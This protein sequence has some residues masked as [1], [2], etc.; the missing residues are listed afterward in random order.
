VLPVLTADDDTWHDHSAHWWETETNWWSFNVPERKLGGWLYTQALGVQQVVNGGAWVWDDS[1]AGAIYERNQKGL[2][3]PERGDLRDITFPNGV[4]VQA[5]EPLMKYRTTYSDPGGFQ[6]DLLHEGIMPPHSHAIGAWPFWATRHFD[7]PM[8]VTGT[9]VLLGEELPIDCYSVRDRSW[10][11]RPM[12]PTPPDKRL[13]PGTLKRD[14][15]PARA[16]RPH[17]VGYAFATQDARD[18]FMAFTDPWIDEEGVAS[19]AV[20][21]GYLLRDGEYAPLVEGSRWTTLAEGTRFIQTI[22]LEARDTLGRELKADGRLVSRHG[23]TGPGGTGLF[24]WT[25]S[26]GREGWGEDQS[27]GPAEW[28]EALDGA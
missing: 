27:Y 2:P 3:F 19:D 1:D 20:D 8:H 23:T 25:W 15:P 17:S 7:Q 18:A 9:I 28:F 16:R 22:H 26:G 12:G 10:G 5:L 24:H 6:C 13:P 14:N 4:S 11:P 21:T